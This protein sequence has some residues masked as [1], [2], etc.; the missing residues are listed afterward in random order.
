MPHET[1]TDA[2]PR[3]TTAR[4]RREVDEAKRLARIYALEEAAKTVET[5]RTLLH[6]QREVLDI[7][8]EDS[9]YTIAAEAI[10]KLMRETP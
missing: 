3:Y 4:L 2:H 10:R 8:R 6:E 5:I 7:G 9:A 1:D